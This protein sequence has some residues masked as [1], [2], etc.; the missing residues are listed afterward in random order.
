MKEKLTEKNY[1]KSWKRITIVCIVM[2]FVGCLLSGC[3]VVPAGE[4]KTGAGNKLLY[5]KKGGDDAGEYKNKDVI[6]IDNKVYGTGLQSAMVNVDANQDYGFVAAE[7][8]VTKIRDIAVIMYNSVL[9][10]GYGGDKYV[11]P[12]ANLSGFSINPEEVLKG[13]LDACQGI[14]TNGGGAAGAIG[15]AMKTAAASILVAMW[16]MTA[17]SQIINEKFTMEVALKTLMQLMCGIV[18][19]VNSDII[20]SAFLQGS[21]AIVGGG[22][23]LADA[24]PGFRADIE[25][26]LSRVTTFNLGVSLFSIIR[27]GIT[28]WFDM[29]ALFSIGLLLLPLIGQLMCGYKI[30]SVIVMRS[31]EMF[32]RI[33]FAPIPIAFG[34]GQGFSQD[35]IR[36]IRGMAACMLQP[37]LISAGVACTA[38]IAQAVSTMFGQSVSG[39]AGSFALFVA[40]LVLSAFI[41]ETKHLIHEIIAR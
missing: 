26:N 1:F 8:G 18:I 23:S 38:E 24:F 35:I 29:G 19:V 2:M 40:Y 17:V 34:A 25:D 30:I 32:A 37:M 3:G 33:T 11:T 9:D 12:S 6:V 10:A 27:F 31:L 28:V 7:N 36:Y 16:L 21:N 41:G 15:G 22:G 13:A 14:L 39:I 5:I 4:Y 20:A